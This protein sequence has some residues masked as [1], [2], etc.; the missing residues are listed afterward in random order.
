MSSPHY[1]M[2]TNNSHLE[3]EPSNA[4]RIHCMSHAFYEQYQLGYLRHLVLTRNYI[5]AGLLVAEDNNLLDLL[6]NWLY[7]NHF[8]LKHDS[9]WKSP[10]VYGSAH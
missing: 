1:Y 2:H 9:S 5:S 3:N 7:S 8:L 10:D 4:L 6:Y